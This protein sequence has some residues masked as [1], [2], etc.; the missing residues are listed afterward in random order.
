MKQQRVLLQIA[1][2]IA[3]LQIALHRSQPHGGCMQRLAGG[4]LSLLRTH[5]L[6][7]P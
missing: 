1:Y 2:V 6:T 5:A 7:A 4:S 3:S